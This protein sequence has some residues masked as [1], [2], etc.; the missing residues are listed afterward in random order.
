VPTSLTTWDE[1]EAWAGALLSACSGAALCTVAPF[2]VYLARSDPVFRRCL[3]RADA[4]LVD[5][6]GVQSALRLAGTRNCRRLTGR[7]LVTRLYNGT[8]LAGSR[9]ALVGGSPDAG[10]VLASTRPDWLVL[11]GAF[12]ARPEGPSVALTAAQLAR[13]RTQVVVVALGTP[14]GELWA[15]AL[16]GRHRCLYLATG[17][18]IDAATGVR[19]PPPASV[20]TMRLEWAWR[21]AQDRSLWPRLAHGASAVPGLFWKAG[22]HRWGAR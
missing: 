11:G 18:A 15:Q 6:S 14:K 13:H 9:V 5:G 22:R 8:F 21:A 17:G 10:S 2:Q 7:E 16:L 1:L 3:E 12:P 4:V 19:R 20:E